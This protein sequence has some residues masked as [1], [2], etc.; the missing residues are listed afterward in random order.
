MIDPWTLPPTN[1]MR[2]IPDEQLGTEPLT[3]DEVA[4][5]EADPRLAV[6]PR[7]DYL[8]RDELKRVAWVKWQRN[9]G[10]ID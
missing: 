9:H 8:D 2:P 7:G 6:Y 4:R 10:L 1:R 3:A 5:L